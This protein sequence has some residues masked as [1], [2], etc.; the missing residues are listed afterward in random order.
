[1][2]YIVFHSH[3]KY[4]AVLSERT[5]ARWVGTSLELWVVERKVEL[6]GSAPRWDFNCMYGIAESVP[7]AVASVTY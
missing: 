6:P 7:R 4:A 2:K 3:R 1:M 5:S